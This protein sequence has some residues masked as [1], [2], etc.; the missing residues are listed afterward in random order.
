M[1]ARGGAS[2]A[3]WLAMI[4][5]AL[6]AMTMIAVAHNHEV[7]LQVTTLSVYAVGASSAFLSFSLAI[8][9]LSDISE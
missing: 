9:H 6:G 7:G 5:I 2:P 3:Q 8:A 1:I 4:L